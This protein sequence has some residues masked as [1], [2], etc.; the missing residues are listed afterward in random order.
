MDSYLFSFNGLYRGIMNTRIR[1]AIC[2]GLYIIPIILCY[3]L[4]TILAFVIWQ[5]P[6][7]V[8]IQIF[9]YVFLSMDIDS[10][11]YFV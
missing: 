7:N 5:N 10:G 9:D 3:L 1:L 11:Q 6:L 2:F 4:V 8:Y